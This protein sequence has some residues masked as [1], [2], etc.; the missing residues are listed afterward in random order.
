M[1]PTGVFRT[2]LKDTTVHRYLQPLSA[3]DTTLDS[4]IVIVTATDSLGLSDTAQVRVNLVSGPKV[5]V[6]APVAGDSSPAGVGLSVAARAQH[7]DRINRIDIRVR[8]ESTWPTKLD[9]TITQV[10]TTAPRDITFNG[11]VR[12]PVDAPIRSRI[13]VSATAINTDRQPGSS[14]PVVVFVRSTAAAVPRVTQTVAPKSEFTDSVTVS[15]TG[16]GIT[17]IGL[18]IRDS[19]GAVVKADT[20]N[21]PPPFNGNVK[22]TVGLNLPPTQQGK[23]LGVTA[24]AI[25]QA[26]RT[27]FAVP[28]STPEIGR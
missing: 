26:G 22:Q 17:T 23:K 24:F 20:V 28:L 18:I 12:I 5:N 13:T 7:P 10:Y 4:L 11:V 27:G 3:T 15:A 9:T 16:Q 2:G 21:L 6:V 14:T 1:P 25:D 19:T 8:G